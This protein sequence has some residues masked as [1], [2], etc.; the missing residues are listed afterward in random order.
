MIQKTK[1]SDKYSSEIDMTIDFI[2]LS[3]IGNFGGLYEDNGRNG[4]GTE[5]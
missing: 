3:L 5:E 4:E 1:N 2:T